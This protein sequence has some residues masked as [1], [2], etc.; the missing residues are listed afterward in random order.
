MYPVCLGNKV[1]KGKAGRGSQQEGRGKS[2]REICGARRGRAVRRRGRGRKSARA[3]CGHLK[4]TGRCPEHSSF[5][6]QK[7]GNHSFGR[8]VRQKK[9][10]VLRRVLSRGGKGEGRHTVACAK[11]GG[12]RGGKKSTHTGKRSGRILPDRHWKVG[13]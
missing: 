7:R 12:S 2:E 9:K 10:S 1:G 4:N 3:G 13:F 8:G 6:R 5:E 11:Y